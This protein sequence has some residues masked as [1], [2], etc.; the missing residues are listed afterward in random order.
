MEYRVEKDSMGE[1]EVPADAL[2]GASTHP[3]SA[4]ARARPLASP[5]PAGAGAGKGRARRNWISEMPI[6]GAPACCRHA[7]WFPP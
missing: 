5:A 2:Y 3:S 7:P 6:I 4:R 1:V